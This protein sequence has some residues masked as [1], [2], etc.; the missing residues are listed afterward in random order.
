MPKPK[1]PQ[2]IAKQYERKSYSFSLDPIR[3]EELKLLAEK[4]GVSV[5]Y[6]VDE[7]I[8]YYLENV[9]ENDKRK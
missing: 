5:S 9:P 1:T 6:L 8:R 7:A 2:E 3:T 4:A